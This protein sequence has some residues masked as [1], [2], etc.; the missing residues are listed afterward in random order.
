[1]K[2]IC[3][4]YNHTSLIFLSAVK[5][6]NYSK[7]GENKNHKYKAQACSEIIIV[8]AL[9]LSLNNVANKNNLT[10]AELLGNIEGGNAGNENHGYSAKQSGYGEGKYYSFK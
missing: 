4:S 3:L 8:S 1:M 9:E 6:I 10:A 5:V 2:R 7:T